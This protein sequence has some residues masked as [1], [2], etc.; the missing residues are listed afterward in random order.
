MFRGEAEAKGEREI[1]ALH[2]LTSLAAERLSM[3]IIKGVSYTD[4]EGARALVESGEA[5]RA[6]FWVFV[7][8]A[9]WAPRQ[10]QGELERDSWFLA[11]ADSGTL[12]KELLRQGTELPPPA[13]VAASEPPHVPRPDLRPHPRLYR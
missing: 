4:F 1:I 8:Y 13:Y 12:L 10:L 5:D 7:G 2:S 6:D 11:S 9:G 3:P